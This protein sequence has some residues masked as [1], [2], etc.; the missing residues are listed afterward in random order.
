MKLKNFMVFGILFLVPVIFV[1]G[2][3]EGG[4]LQSIFNS[5]TGTEVKVAP[6]DVLLIENIQVVPNMPITATSTFALSFQVTNVGDIGE[7]SKEA[8]SVKA[9]LYDWG[10]CTPVKVPDK[11]GM[12][13]GI[14]KQEVNPV[15]IYPQGS[16]IV[17]WEIDTPDNDQLGRM[18]GK[19][20]I[21]F[22]VEYDFSA[23]TTSDLVLID[24]NRLKEI[25]R[26][27]NLPSAS[28]TMTQSRGPIKISVDFES[29]PPIVSDLTIPLIIFVTDTG[30]GLFQNVDIGDLILEVPND[31]DIIC[32][33]DWMDEGTETGGI[34]ELKNTREIPLIKG[35]TPPIRCDLDYTGSAIYDMKTYSVRARMDYTYNLYKEKDVIVRPTYE[36]FK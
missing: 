22:K 11:D 27:G 14:S 25:H 10:R 29:S 6:K 17:E 16:E 20:P 13:T 32:Y 23:Y 5:L 35:K 33:S 8:T 36:G 24:K 12:V 7:G 30:T 34:I 21:R 18:E 1:S 15:Y 28:A 19:C 4:G 31:F 2:C 3:V 26:A 9:Y